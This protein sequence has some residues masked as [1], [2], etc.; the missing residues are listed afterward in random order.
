MKSFLPL[1]LLAFAGF[2]SVSG[3]LPV[4]PPPPFK[5][6]FIK[7]ALKGLIKGSLGGGGDE[8]DGCQTKWEEVWKPQCTTSSE[9]VR[10]NLTVNFYTDEI[11]C[12]C[13]CVAASPSNSAVRSTWRSAGWSSRSS[14]RSP[15]RTG[16][17]NDGRLPEE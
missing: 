6:G 1:C 17:S 8:D 7:G 4:L 10:A 3:L 15:R 14:A 9:K 12:W 11:L 2:E 5:H 13:R 16:N